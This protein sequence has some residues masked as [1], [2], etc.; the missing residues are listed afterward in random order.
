GFHIHI[1][2]FRPGQIALVEFHFQQSGGFK[3]HVGKV[4]VEKLDLYEMA[5][6]ESIMETLFFYSEMIQHLI[7]IPEIYVPVLYTAP[8]SIFI[9]PGRIFLPVRKVF[10]VHS[11]HIEISLPYVF[12]STIIPNTSHI[13]V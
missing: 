12:I 4:A 9:E 2:E 11:L 13:L 8:F 7:V 10:Q 1:R 3:L 6:P 5:A